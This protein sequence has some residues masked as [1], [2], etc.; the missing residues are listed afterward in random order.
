MAEIIKSEIDVLKEVNAAV[1]DYQLGLKSPEF[2]E[3]QGGIDKLRSEMFEWHEIYETKFNT[4]ELGFAVSDSPNTD[5]LN[6]DARLAFE[7]GP[8]HKREYKPDEL[9]RAAIDIAKTEN[10]F[11]WIF[12]AAKGGVVCTGAVCPMKTRGPNKGHPNFRKHDPSTK[13]IVFVPCIDV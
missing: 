3:E 5:L 13:T 9:S 2:A 6:E 8:T 1:S 4:N 12:E 11:P 7:A 10:W